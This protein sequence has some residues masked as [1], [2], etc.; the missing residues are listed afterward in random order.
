MQP[1]NLCLR[2]SSVIKVDSPPPKL[3][4]EV[5]IWCT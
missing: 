5:D 4:V 1:K 3:V 2:A